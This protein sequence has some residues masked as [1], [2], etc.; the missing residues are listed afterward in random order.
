MNIRPKNRIFYPYLNN[1]FIYRDVF[2]AQ[3]NTGVMSNFPQMGRMELNRKGS[4]KRSH[5][6]VGCLGDT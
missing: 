2:S 1:L 6:H 3:M 4:R 5:G